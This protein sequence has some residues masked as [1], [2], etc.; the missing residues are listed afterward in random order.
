[1]RH[2]L[3]SRLFPARRSARVRQIQRAR[4]PRRRLPR[5]RIPLADS[6]SGRLLLLTIAFVVLGEVLIYL[7]SIARYRLVFLEARLASAHLASLALEDR[8]M[9]VTPGLE[10]TLL[11]NGMVVSVTL[12]RPGGPVLMLGETAPAAMTVDLRDQTPIP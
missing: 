11:A 9:A 1:M 4:S 5:R 8:D 12:T 3:V 6:L 2:R 7:P 10:K